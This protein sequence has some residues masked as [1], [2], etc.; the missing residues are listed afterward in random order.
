MTIQVDITQKDL[1]QKLTMCRKLVDY[2]NMV[3]DVKPNWY[4]YLYY[5]VKLND[6]SNQIES[7]GNYRDIYND[8]HH[9]EQMLLSQI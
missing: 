9:I 5:Y 3:E 6:I 1:Y 4:G 7:G 8:L 2:F